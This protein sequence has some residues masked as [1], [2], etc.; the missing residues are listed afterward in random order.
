MI[1]DKVFPPAFN[2]PNT[3]TE[4]RKSFATCNEYTLSEWPDTPVVRK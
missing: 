4:E 3:D 2:G 1:Y